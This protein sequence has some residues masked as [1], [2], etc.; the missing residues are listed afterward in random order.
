MEFNFVNSLQDSRK[1]HT[2]HKHTLISPQDPETLLINHKLC[3]KTSSLERR[4]LL[5]TYFLMNFCIITKYLKT[6][7]IILNRIQE[8]TRSFALLCN[9]QRTLKN[10]RNSN[11]Y[12]CQGHKDP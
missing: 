8:S 3:F 7:N 2:I 4:F 9:M 11:M 6:A 5:Y 10:Y 12:K 1:T